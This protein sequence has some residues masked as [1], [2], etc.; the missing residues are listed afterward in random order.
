MEALSKTQKAVQQKIEESLLADHDKFIHLYGE[1]GSGKTFVVQQTIKNIKEFENYTVYYIRGKEELTDSFSTLS[2][3]EEVK[4]PILENTGLT[5]TLSKIIP[6]VFNIGIS[7]GYK[8][9]EEFDKKINFFVNKLKKLPTTNI[10]IIADDFHYW[11]TASKGFLMSLKNSFIKNVEDKKLK[12]I[13]VT[14]T[15]KE[16]SIPKIPYTDLLKLN[17]KIPT[18]NEIPEILKSMNY[19]H[20]N[21]DFKELS[22]VMSM[23]GGNIH[24][25]K[26]LIESYY[27]S[28]DTYLSSDTSIFDVKK[29]L[30]LRL[31]AFGDKQNDFSKVFQTLSILSEDFESKEIKHLCSE[32]ID[33][34]DFLEV[35][36]QRFFLKKSNDFCFSN[37]LMKNIFYEQLK[38]KSLSLHADYSKYLQENRPDKYLSRAFHLSLADK[39]QKQS[40]EIIGL[41]ALA[42]FRNLE[43]SNNFQDCDPI[44]MRLKELVDHNP[45]NYETRKQFKNFLHLK[46]VYEFYFKELYAEANEKLNN[47]SDGSNLFD[48]EVARMKLL[49]SLM[50]NMDTENIRNNVK[51]MSYL[52]KN[53]KEKEKEQWFQC[54][55]VLFSTYANKL[56]DFDNSEII[57]HELRQ[58]INEHSEIDLY[59]YIG[60][61]I[62]RKSFIFETILVSKTHIQDSMEYFQRSD[63]YTQ[64]YFSLCNYAGVLLVLG[65]YNKSKAHLEACL[66]LIKDHPYITF[67]DH[68]KIYNNLFLAEFLKGFRDEEFFNLEKLD[69]IIQ[70]FE[71]K[72]SN[73]PSEKDAI[74]LIN[75]LNLY[76]LKK[77]YRVCHNLLTI[78]RNEVLLDNQDSFYDYYITNIYLALNVVQENWL[79]AEHYMEKLNNTFPEFHKKNSKK[80]YNRNIT[81]QRLVDERICLEPIEL[82]KWVL[83]NS[84]KEDI[85]SE[86]YSRLFLFSDLQFS[87]L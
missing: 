76:I 34:D 46:S 6:D 51:K 39:K 78:L 22:E 71:N 32:I 86:F 36:C 38:D 40:K 19:S 74:M 47:I 56:G 23:T 69:N 43:K 2:Y 37:K 31:E 80:I 1:F 41:F 85:S 63:N 10:V 9:R 16:P 60:Q 79:E 49:V 83:T 42:Y 13:L 61:I 28:N 35:S 5:F 52:L 64:Y 48:A 45:D 29:L 3:A 26:L 77:E 58:F 50:L 55:F 70:K 73:K 15:N 62:N 87:S 17:L 27:L 44:Y 72:I 65:E 81:L 54:A 82:D 84:K 24:F 57:V 14:D 66:N 8:I 12:I 7:T 30:E 18:L 4:V 75:L 59:Q 53:L 11:D 21:F 20:I 33:I 68:Q 67:P 25:L